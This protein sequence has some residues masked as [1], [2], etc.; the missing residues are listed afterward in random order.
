MHVS[1]S[2]TLLLFAPIGRQPGF[3]SAENKWIETF[4]K[5]ILNPWQR[6][7]MYLCCESVCVFYKNELYELLPTQT[8][9]NILPPYLLN[10]A[11]ALQ[12]AK[13]IKSSYC[14]RCFLV[15]F[16]QV[17]K[18]TAMTQ[19]Q[20]SLIDHITAVLFLSSLQY[21]TRVLKFGILSQYRALVRLA[22]LAQFQAMQACSH[23][24][25]PTAFILNVQNYKYTTC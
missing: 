23:A 16:L 4:V 8:T 24:T 25:L 11:S 21:F 5:S 15:C 3:S 6:V 10:W 17:V 20:S 18:C 7:Y 9:K 12:I 2:S 22:F 14:L 1:H 19:E 13:F